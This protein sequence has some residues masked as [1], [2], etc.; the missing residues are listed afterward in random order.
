MGKSPEEAPAAYN[1]FSPL[2]R[3]KTPGVRPRARY[4]IVYGDKDPLVDHHQSE[5]FIA[6]LREVGADVET[7]PLPGS[8]HSWFTLHDDHPGRRRV[9]QEPNATVAPVLLRFL[10]RSLSA[11]EHKDGVSTNEP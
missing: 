8:G 10:R 7:M 5:L 11:I 9:D 3:L 2:H 6:A 1:L 4:L